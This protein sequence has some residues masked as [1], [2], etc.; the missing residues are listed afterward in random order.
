M[1]ERSPS[2][3]QVQQAFTAY[4]RDPDAAPPPELD[5]ERMGIYR[6]LIR[7]NLTGLLEN[8][9]PV[10]VTMLGQ[11]TFEGLVTRFLAT[12]HSQAPLFTELAAEFVQWLQADPAPPHPALPELAH[13]EWVETALYQLDAHPLQPLAPGDLLGQPLQCSPLACVLFYRWPVHELGAAPVP[14]NAPPLPTTLLVRRDD[15]GHVRFSVLGNLAAQ[16]LHA[17]S[18]S[19]GHTGG[20]YLHQLAQHHRLH[21]DELGPPLQALLLQLNEQGVIGKPPT[22]S[23][24]TT[25]SLP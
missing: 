25:R 4:L 1:H 12:H 23:E 21:A 17:I 6:R 2:L 11:D 13:Y 19:P 20:T 10:C 22:P 7:G 16:L 9:F 3:R 15:K 18:T 14:S 5:P 8:A 24:S